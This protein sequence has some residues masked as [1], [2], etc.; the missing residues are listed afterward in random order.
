MPEWSEYVDEHRVRH[1]WECAACGYAFETTVS[2]EAE[3][4]VATSEA[5]FENLKR[6]PSRRGFHLASG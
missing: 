5:A 6:L 4:H 3:Q 2:S 1:L